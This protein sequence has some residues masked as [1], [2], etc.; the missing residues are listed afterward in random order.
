VLE[1]FVV[2]H[3]PEAQL[4]LAVPPLFEHSLDVKQ[5]PFTGGAVTG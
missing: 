3:I 2:P 5:V 4:P 1:F